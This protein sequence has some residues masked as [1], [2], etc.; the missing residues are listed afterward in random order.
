M[1]K[2][3]NLKTTHT[4]QRCGERGW[5]KPCL[6]YKKHQEMYQLPIIVVRNYPKLNVLN[7]NSFSYNCGIGCL[8]PK[9]GSLDERIYFFAFSGFQKPLAFL[10]SQPT[11]NLHT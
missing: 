6:F 3:L 11:P 9:M 2:N 4:H 10:G 8:K 5:L 7:T 1:F